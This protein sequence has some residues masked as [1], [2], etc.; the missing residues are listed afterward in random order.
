VVHAARR[1]LPYGEWTRLWKSGCVGFS[2][3]KAEMLAAIGRNLNNLNAQTSAHLPAGWN[4][5]YHLALLDR[6]TLQREI[7]AGTIHPGMTLQIA[8]DLLA[9]F[10][11]QP[12][13]SHSRK[14]NLKQRLQSF[15]EF[16]CSALPNWSAEDRQM[17]HAEL[18]RLAE[19]VGAHGQSPYLCSSRSPP[20]KISSAF[21]FPG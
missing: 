16:V 1:K 4:T 13:D 9:K 8:K 18:S 5:L 11:G 7:G 2:K 10:R 17:A 6:T 12:I 15:K 20:P 21:S 3:R 14:P 19:E